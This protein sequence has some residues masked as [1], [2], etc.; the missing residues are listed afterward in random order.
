[1]GSGSHSAGNKE[2][3][4]EHEEEKAPGRQPD[5]LRRRRLLD[6]RR[7]VA[8][9]EDDAA[10]NRGDQES[11]P[12]RFHSQRSFI[13]RPSRSMSRPDLVDLYSR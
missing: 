10:E 6:S 12:D 7:D 9:D 11:L 5:L 4:E 13:P 2:A 1:M 3:D 8:Q